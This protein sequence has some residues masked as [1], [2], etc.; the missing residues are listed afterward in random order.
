MENAGTKKRSQKV[1]FSA[2]QLD[3]L[4]DGVVQHYSTLYGSLSESITK[5]KKDAIWKNICERVNASGAVSVTPDKCKTRWEAIK[6]TVKKQVAGA[7]AERQATGGGVAA[8][9]ELTPLEEKVA[10]TLKDAAIHGIIQDGDTAQVCSQ[11]NPPPPPPNPPLVSPPHPFPSL[12]RP[13]PSRTLTD[14]FSMST[15]A[16]GVRC[17]R[18]GRSR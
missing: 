6:C 13:K 7:K 1:V 10:A 11:I 5:L 8:I 14:C 12:P 17:W 9:P 16:R 18:E 4:V 2:A 15:G 3:V